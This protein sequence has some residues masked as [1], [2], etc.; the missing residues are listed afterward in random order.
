MEAVPTSSGP[1]PTSAAKLSGRMTALSSPAAKKRPA[2]MC[3]SRPVTSA[4]A[5]CRPT[6]PCAKA[7]RAGRGGGK[8]DIGPFGFDRRQVPG[9]R[10]DQGA[11]AERALHVVQDGILHAAPGAVADEAALVQGRGVAR[12]AIEVEAGLDRGKGIDGK[13]QK[14]QSRGCQRGAQ[15]AFAQVGDAQQ[16]GR[17]TRGDP[18]HVSLVYARDCALAPL[19]KRLEAGDDDEDDKD[20]QGEDDKREEDDVRRGAQFE[21][22]MDEAQDQKYEEQR[23]R[24]SRRFAAARPG[25]RRRIARRR[26][27]RATGARSR[28]SLRAPRRWQWP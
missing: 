25:S 22:R 24:R 26:R 20:T 21:G 3:A 11:V 16:H 17:K 6:K 14:G 10:H 27:Q 23:C 28:K 12:Q 18:A 1:M 19:Q 15:A 13:G 7:G 4:S 8:V 5:G 2:E 9:A